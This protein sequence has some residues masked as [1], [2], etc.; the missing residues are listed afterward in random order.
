MSAVLSDLLPR[1]PDPRAGA[2]LMAGGTALL[3]CLALLVCAFLGLLPWQVAIQGTAGV[4][5]LVLLFYLMMRTGLNR[6]FRDPSLA[7]EQTAAAILFLAYVMYHAAPVREA[8][9]LFFLLVMLFAVQR[10]SA[11]RLAALSVLALLAYGT[12]LHLSYLRDQSAMDVKG[13]LTQFAVLM[14]ALPWF[15][16]MGGYVNRLR[17]R[18]SETN[19]SLEQAFGRMQELAARDE[20]TGAYNRR[21][22]METMT[23]EQ[24]RAARLGA[25]CA[26]CLIDVDHFKTVNDTLGHPAGDEVLKRVAAVAA[27]GLRA[28][29]VFGRFGGEEFL[30]VLPDTDRAGALLVAERIRAAVAAETQVTVTIGV[31]QSAK[32]D[33][34][35]VLA[36]ADQALYRGKAAGRNRVV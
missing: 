33:V 1:E 25:S 12:V 34:A 7:T 27:R 19:R 3:A 20:L 35:A 5:T 23:R 18:L 2:A 21:F 28:A 26:V 24:A 15:A 14:I 13:A 32:D 4:A 10:L 17:A 6:R 8:L 22:L 11:A 16:A 36:R 30:A 9:T 31:A 29:D